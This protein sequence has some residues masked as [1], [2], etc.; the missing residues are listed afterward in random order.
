M[1]PVVAALFLVVCTTSLI[2]GQKTRFGEA[3]VPPNPADYTLKVHIAAA[4]LKTECANGFCS[5]VLYADATLNGKKLE[6]SGVAVMVKKT[7]MLIA[8]GDY[9]AKLV[10]DV[11][12]TDGTLFD[13]EYDLLL[14]DNIVW[15]CYTT[16]ISE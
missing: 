9:P 11:H 3:T 2:Y 6:L 8:P 16:G 10:K 7:L 12:N 15:Q 13:Q 14:P 5:N 4:H 1:R